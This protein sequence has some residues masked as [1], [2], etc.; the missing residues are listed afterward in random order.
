MKVLFFSL[1]VGL[2]IISVAKVSADIEGVGCPEE[3]SQYIP[4]PDLVVNLWSGIPPGG[5]P[6]GMEERWE[7]GAETQTIIRVSDVSIPT[8]SLYRAPNP[9]GTCVLIFPGGGYNI[10]AYNYEGTEIAQWLNSI[11]IT[12]IVVKYRV[13]RREGVAKHSAALADA[14]R[15]VRIARYKAIEWGYD[16]DKIGTLGFSAGGHLTVMTGTRFGDEVYPQQDMVDRINPRPDFLIPIYPAY[17]MEDERQ[18]DAS[19][20][21][22]DE[23]TIT[24]RTPP[25]FISVTDDDENRAA[26][27]A[28]YYIKMKEKGVPCELHIFA[29][30]GHGYALRHQNGPA[31]GWDRL[32]EDWLRTIGMLE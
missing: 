2:L 5:I 32:C 1:V 31:A 26:A 14:L 21:L 8:M 19:V 3:V 13:P 28:R 4:Q 15:A 9:N 17:M 10:L 12:A 18:Y 11:G 23:V 27:S 25:T 20:P 24:E 30:G 29:K 6:E 7:I 22:A 16:Q